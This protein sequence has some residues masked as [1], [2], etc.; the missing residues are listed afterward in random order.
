M[1]TAKYYIPSG[2]CIQKKDYAEGSEVIVHDSLQTEQHTFFTKNKRQVLD[3]GGVYPDVEVPGDSIS[4]P[5]MQLIR[6]NIIFDFAVQYHQQHPE[7]EE[8]PVVDDSVKARFNAF[9][10][11]RHFQYRFA[12]TSEIEHLRDYVKKE[13]LSGKVN[14]LLDRLEEIFR[15]TTEKEA[16]KNQAQIL[17]FLHLE[18]VEKYFGRTER[19][20]ISLQRDT[21]AQR[22][23]EVLQN[24]S[25]YRTILAKG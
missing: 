22:A 15:K 4:L 19:D 3:K 23:L 6:S 17:D 16:L 9:L 24:I 13:K 25:K 14:D 21:Q 20:R 18:M 1:T 2:R 11:A 7:W 8:H 5:L 12:G 10:R